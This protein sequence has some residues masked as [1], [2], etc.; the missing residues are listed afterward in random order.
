[1]NASMT[2]NPNI[3]APSTPKF[4]PSAPF[5]ASQPFNLLSFLSVFSPIILIVFVM[6][7]SFFFQNV[8][9]F[10]YLGFVIGV[11]ILR[12]IFLQAIGVEKNKDMCG[13][14]RYTSYGNATFTT[15]IFGF[16]IMYLFL[17]MFNASAINWILMVFLLTYVFFD[18]GVKVMQG[19]IVASKHMSYVI[20]DFFSGMLLSGAIVA[21]MYAGG[22]DRYLFFADSTSNGT[23]CSMPKKQTFKCQVFKNGELVTSRNV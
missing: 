23:I 3:N 17:P 15:F 20:G 22:S 10:V 5:I 13:V 12:S 8:K 9:G 6:S 16:T 14:V 1:M 2:A 18:L 4:G 19:C 11:V 21:A 7:Y